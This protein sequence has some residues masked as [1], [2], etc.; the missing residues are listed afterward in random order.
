MNIW[1]PYQDKVQVIILVRRN[2][3]KL[4][5]AVFQMDGMRKRTCRVF[6]V[7]ILFLKNLSIFLN[8]WKWRKQI[9]KVL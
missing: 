1:M 2:L 9:I 7:N 4:F 5:W 8:T 6:T 3:M